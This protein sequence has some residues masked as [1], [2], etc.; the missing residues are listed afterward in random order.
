M[1][2]D[3][4]GAYARASLARLA[5]VAGALGLRL[6]LTLRAGDGFVLP[7]GTRHSAL[8]GPAGCVCVEGHRR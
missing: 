7:P 3:E 8:V 5:R 4:A 6:T 2:K 1:Q